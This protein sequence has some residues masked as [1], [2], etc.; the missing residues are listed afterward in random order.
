MR[1]DY[2]SRGIQSVESNA[3]SV[4]SQQPKHLHAEASPCISSL[5]SEFKRVVVAEPVGARERGA[6]CANVRRLSPQCAKGEDACL[7][8]SIF[9]LKW[10]NKLSAPYR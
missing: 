8:V 4:I 10:I 3:K 7:F 9:L 6:A 5:I 2:A 1:C